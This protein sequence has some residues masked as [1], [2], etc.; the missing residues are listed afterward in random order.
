[1]SIE[2]DDDEE[3]IPRR[4]MGNSRRILL[5]GLVVLALIC[6]V[7]FLIYNIL[8][9]GDQSIV[10]GS[11]PTPTLAVTT[12][13]VAEATSEAEEPTPTFTRVVSAE[14][15]T[16]AGTAEATEE[17]TP[18]LTATPA[19]R[20][21]PASTPVAS[22][23]VPTAAPQAGAIDQLLENGDFEQ[24]FDEGGVAMG[25]EP[26]R[27]DSVQAL[28]GR[29]S[30]PYVES[31]VSAQRIS[32]LGATQNNRYAGI[33]QLVNVVPSEVYTLELNG[34]IRTGF[35]DVTQSSYGYRVQY[36]I[37]QEGFKNWQNVPEAD[38]IELPWDEQPLN[39]PDTK[40]LTYTTRIVPTS[41]TMTLFV[42][43]W[44][45]WADP[46]EAQYTFDSFSLI[47]PSVA[48]APAPATSTGTG[49]ET[50]TG[51]DT[52]TAGTGTADEL[53]DKPLPTTGSGDAESFIRDG[54]F[55]GALL[56]LLL[57][58]TGAIYR[59]RWSY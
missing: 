2:E 12:S 30:F 19:V 18:Q 7:G 46:G 14:T 26:F 50:G 6:L 58:A 21:T 10:G 8:T 54:R 11:T 23:N 29:E 5:M 47:G 56:V 40:F 53:I 28:Y 38:W 24:G 34:Q 13:P 25:W 36:A 59:A 48:P 41:D 57:L 42:R 27:N 44:N 55:W 9:T 15:E 4:G 16:A 17:V 43:A 51:P 32:L 49:T 39:A 1:M 52:S 20:T 3:E 22:Q 33:Y 31:G 35:G 37:S 45:K